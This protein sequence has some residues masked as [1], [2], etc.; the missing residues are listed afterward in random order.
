MFGFLALLLSTF[1]SGLLFLVDFE[2]YLFVGFSF[3]Q[4]ATEN[5]LI[6]SQSSTISRSK[7]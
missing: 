1:R 6:V 5:P 3:I 7:S 4:R 2:E